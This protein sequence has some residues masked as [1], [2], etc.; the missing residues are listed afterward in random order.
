MQ[1]FV[2]QNPTR[3]IFGPG[4]ITEL[5]A[6]TAPFGQRVLL[7]HGLHSIHRH[8][9]FPVVHESLGRAG[10]TVFIHGGV[11]PN[12]EIRQVRQ[13]IELARKEKVDVVVAVGGGSVMDTAKAIA[14]GAPVGHDAWLFFRGKKSIRSALPLV[15]APTI[16]GSGSETNSGMVLSNAGTRQKIGIG[17]RH[18]FPKTAILDPDLTIT[19][20]SGATTLGAVDAISHL[21]EF[22]LNRQEDFT[23]LQDNYS[24][25]LMR[26]LME[27]CQALHTNPADSCAR[28]SLLWASALAL[29]GLSTAGL[30]RVDFP[31]HMIEHSLSA[32]Y[33]IPHGAGLAAI[34]PGALTFQA[35][36][37]PAR[38]A[39]FAARVL[40]LDE[41][42]QRNLAA[43]GIH[44]FAQ[45]LHNTGAPTSLADL[46]IPAEDIP[47]IAA[48][49][50]EQARLWRLHQYPP[51][52]VEAILRECLGPGCWAQGLNIP[53]DQRSGSR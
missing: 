46:S 4:A 19:V 36:N 24:E 34:L 1:D 49:T 53:Q 7:V 38:H 48:N 41:G 47:I 37:A 10:L 20:P 42:D 44:C 32:L 29:G 15:C 35:R 6:Q 8:G 13:G 18:L 43:R 23:P 52:I 28:G 22:Y 3:V 30:G 33:D 27:N 9:L 45:W 50:R 39:R 31:L 26:T 5:G 17:N 21:L 11:R 16:A 25:G 2:F 40:G 51:E 14:A 12:P